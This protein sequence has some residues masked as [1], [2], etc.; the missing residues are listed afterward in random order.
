MRAVN[1]PRLSRTLGLTLG[2][3]V[4]FAA[5]FVAYVWSEKQIDRANAVR[6]Q[7]YRLADE[8][9]QSSDDLTR[10]VRTYVVTGDP[11]YKWHYQE[12]L[13]IRDG[14]KPRPLLYQDIY[15]DL[16][17]TDDKRPRAF[18]LAV[19][20]LELMR[21]AGFT[22]EEFAR[23]AVAKANSD[24][25]T[26]TE[27]YAM[28]LVEPGSASP[29]IDRG[30]AIGMLFDATYHDAKAGIMEPISAFHRMVDQRTLEAVEIATAHAE[31]MRAVFVVFGLM[32]VSLL[33]SVRRKLHDIL[34]GSVNEL[35]AR[36]THLGGGHF[37][38]AIP[39]AEGRENSVL[40]WLS[41]TQVNLARI[42]TQRRHAE[43]QV[44]SRTNELHD[45]VREHKLA[46]ERVEYLAYYDSLTSLPNR[47]MFSKLLNQAIALARRDG[48]RLAVL[49][50]DL[51]HFK[52][53]NDTLGHEAGDML[54]EEV[55]GRLRACL[56]E[57]D[58]VARLGGDEFVVLLPALQDP[59]YIERVARKILDAIG[60]SFVI[61]GHEFV[62]TASI[63][64]SSFPADGLDEQALMK[65]ADI[66]MYKAK[67]D[68]KNNFQ[69]YSEELDRNSVDRLALESSL[70]LALE[71]GEFEI[72]YQPKIDAQSAAIAG[73]EALLRW[74]HPSLGVMAPAKFLAIAEETGLIVS[75]GKWVLGT[76]CAQS[77]A[78]G[79][80]GLP[81]LTM[82]INLSR[83][84][85]NDDGLVRDITSILGEVGMKPGLL[86]LEVA[87]STV[88]Q[89]VE[90]A[91]ATLKA[92]RQAGVRVAIDGFGAGYLSLT[93]LS[94]FPIDT[95]KIDGSFVRGLTDHVENRRIADAIIAMGRTLSLTVIAE[96]VETKEQADF[97]RERACD[98][99]QGF[100]FSKAVTAD[101][102]AQLL[103]TQGSL[104]A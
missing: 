18:A 76:A 100:Y 25:L 99:L 24:A 82:A 69:L 61:L 6:L 3:F 102:F 9:R 19:P 59:A 56:R 52:N 27:F 50:L 87:E 22:P 65:N 32:L 23:L 7:S 90:K 47:G 33:W 86:E 5:T 80:A 39:V 41:E 95:I 46:A 85:F 49:F 97:L 35:H 74:K 30:R 14:K 104:A 66:A 60:R 40:G 94:K 34:G 11:I 70:R 1:L 92:F 13:D 20:L 77:V 81:A 83:R 64:V 88:M 8:L 53:I 16:V 17:L 75:I 15:W 38:S 4:V 29:E 10:M 55:A 44:S 31:R 57:S 42:D 79:N 48:R 43:E 71:R 98:E 51:D 58:I 96:G 67:A 62:V 73:V 2:M 72:H 28:E 45:S 101:E 37:D 54:L 63:G 84:Q 91:V 12:I 36:I 26:R 93:N 103:E 68:G 78:W 89:D 21:Q